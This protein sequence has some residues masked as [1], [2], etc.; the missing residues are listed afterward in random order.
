VLAASALGPF[1]QRDALHALDVI[2]QALRRPA[3]TVKPGHAQIGLDAGVAEAGGL[4]HACEDPLRLK[5]KPSGQGRLIAGQQKE[6]PRAASARA[7]KHQAKRS[8]RG[9]LFVVG[10]VVIVL[11]PEVQLAAGEQARRLL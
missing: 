9:V 1:A 10:G 8:K 2:E 11:A 3:W 4:A 7:V 5:R 6:G